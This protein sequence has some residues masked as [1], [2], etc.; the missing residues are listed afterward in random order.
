MSAYV[1][2]A[3]SYALVKTSLQRA[4]FSWSGK[5][6]IETIFRETYRRHV[7]VDLAKHLKKNID[8]KEMMTKED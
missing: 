8:L 2:Y 6:R 3:Y 5:V 7:S 4:V 1:T